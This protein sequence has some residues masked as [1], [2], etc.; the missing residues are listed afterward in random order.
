[1]NEVMGCSYASRCENCDLA[2]CRYQ[3]DGGL[4]EAIRLTEAI[5]QERE[6]RR[7]IGSAGKAEAMRLAVAKEH[8]VTLDDMTSPSRKKQFVAAR[9][10]AFCRMRAELGMKTAAIARMFNCTSP[11][12]TYGILHYGSRKRWSNGR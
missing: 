11:T 10:D 6:R 5:Y 1:M 12:V 7:E 2:L 4:M 3:V 8:C 9:Q